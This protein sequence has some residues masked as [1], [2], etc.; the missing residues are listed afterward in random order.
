L[1][2]Y[3]GEG[4][5]WQTFDPC[6][7]AGWLNDLHHPNYPLMNCG[8]SGPGTFDM[9]IFGNGRAVFRALSLGLMAWAALGL[10]LVSAAHADQWIRY[11]DLSKW[12][13]TDEAWAYRDLAPET[14]WISHD[15]VPFAV[16]A[17]EMIGPTGNPDIV[18]FVLDADLELADL[19][20][21][22]LREVIW[23]WRAVTSGPHMGNI[24]GDLEGVEVIASALDEIEAQGAMIQVAT[25]LQEGA[26]QAGVIGTVAFFSGGAAA[27]KALDDV[28]VDAALDTLIATPRRAAWEFG[29]GTILEQAAAARAQAGFI[30]LRLRGVGGSA[31]SPLSHESIKEA[32]HRGMNLHVLAFPAARMMMA[33]QDNTSAGAQIGRLLGVGVDTAASIADPKALT[34]RQVRALLRSNDI[35]GTLTETVPPFLDFQEAA[36]AREASFGHLVPSGAEKRL[37]PLV[38]TAPQPTEA[39]DP[40]QFLCPEPESTTFTPDYPLYLNGDPFDR[41]GIEQDAPSANWISVRGTPLNLRYTPAF[42]DQDRAFGALTIIT[43]DGK[44][45][46]LAMDEDLRTLAWVAYLAH[47]LP[48][49]RVTP[50]TRDRLDRVL[51]AS[52]QAAPDRVDWPL[53]LT[54]SGFQRQFAINRSEGLVSRLA[55]EGPEETVL[56]AQLVAL[57]TPVV[58][59]QRDFIAASLDQAAGR[60]PDTALQPS[61]LVAAAQRSV[62]VEYVLLP[63]LDVLGKRPAGVAWGFAASGGLA[64]VL[65][66]AR[67]TVMADLALCIAQGAP[68]F[69]LAMRPMASVRDMRLS[70]LPSRAQD[71]ARAAEQARKREAEAQARRAAAAARAEEADRRAAEAAARPVAARTAGQF[72]FQSI[73]PHFEARFVLPEPRGLVAANAMET[74]D[75]RFVLVEYRRHSDE[76]EAPDATRAGLGVFGTDGRFLHLFEDVSWE[77]FTGNNGQMLHSGDVVYSAEQGAFLRLT[78]DEKR[79]DR[80]EAQLDVISGET[81]EKIRQLS[82]DLG[83]VSA[84]SGI[85]LNT[86]PSAHA[87]QLNFDG[88][89]QNLV[90]DAETLETRLRVDSTSHIYWND[91]VVAVNR[92]NEGVWQFWMPDMQGEPLEIDLSRIPEGCNASLNYRARFATIFGEGKDAVLGPLTVS[93]LQMRKSCPGKEEAAIFLS[94]ATGQVVAPDRFPVSSAGHFHRFAEKGSGRWMIENATDPSAPVMAAPT[95][96]P[97]FAGMVVGHEAQLIWLYSDGQSF[98]LANPISGGA[99]TFS[100]DGEPTK[101][102]LA[103]AHGQADAYRPP[104]LNASKGYG[105]DSN[106]RVFSPLAE[107][108]YLLRLDGEVRYQNVQGFSTTGEALYTR[109]FSNAWRNTTGLE[110]WRMEVSANPMPPNL[111]GR[112]TVL[113]GLPGLAAMEGDDGIDLVFDPTGP[114]GDIAP[115][116][117]PPGFQLRVE[118]DHAQAKRMYVELPDPDRPTRRK[119]L[120]TLEQLSAEGCAVPEVETLAR[121]T[122]TGHAVY[123]VRFSSDASQVWV[124][125]DDARRLTAYDSLTLTPLLDMRHP[126]DAEENPTEAM[127]V[128]EELTGSDS[129]DFSTDRD[130]IVQP[131]QS[132]ARFIR[133]STGQLIGNYRLFADALVTDVVISERLDALVGVGS[134]LGR[135]ELRAIDLG[136]REEIWTTEFHCRTC[137]RMK[138]HVARDG[139]SAV[140]ESRRDRGLY[141]LDLTNGSVQP[142][143][144]G[145]AGR[146]AFADN[147]RRMFQ[148][149]R[150]GLA[151]MSIDQNG[152]LQPLWSVDSDAVGGWALA[153]DPTANRFVAASASRAYR[154]IDGVSKAVVVAEAAPGDRVD[155]LLGMAHGVHGTLALRFGSEGEFLMQRIG[156]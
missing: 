149:T 40:N 143:G 74:R 93:P 27:A 4:K 154:V 15:G 137:G 108:F 150:D 22:T 12:R 5:L 92:K 52:V 66:E 34:V 102:F 152:R 65:L 112:W 13:A 60:T 148:L 118:E 25:T 125:T 119:T 151:G 120:A 136:R 81:F 131:Y 49:M 80:L 140:L 96:S 106:G 50:D 89:R 63:A 26:I 35:I 113:K 54:P 91:R 123:R 72:L 138:L 10:H 69:P 23:A 139:Q 132:G 19:D 147:P 9:T 115:V 32:L 98:G 103:R 116:L 61:H 20:E 53:Q 99:M 83:E 73:V 1:T 6:S 133:A 109:F 156:E 17:K 59:A 71:A 14:V 58:R 2:K 43:S 30:D 145:N 111:C 128:S 100:G 130:L 16:F 36:K 134:D 87:I 46:E 31:R 67:Q 8:L 142:I 82:F 28:V 86:L 129:F 77:R 62:L 122:E 105:V 55:L 110:K 42:D 51:A 68:R 88:Y 76:D 64:D 121:T 97:G 84:S 48:Q 56:A 45:Q 79:Q 141:F 7:K 85:W 135:I 37:A 95:G 101:R 117:L 124:L 146:I 94:L 114:D 107:E 21:A 155:S 33:L 153:F 3:P 18:H 126:G 29:A 90:L 78:L 38:A 47:A 57:L 24:Q 75:G 144:S 39:V 41:F 70:D 127:V 11:A 104:F 44:V